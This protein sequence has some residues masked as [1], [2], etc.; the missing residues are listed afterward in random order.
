MKTR[1]TIL[2]IMI[3]MNLAAMSASAT[4]IQDII[5]GGGSIT[6]GHF[7]FSDFSVQATAI[8]GVSPFADLIDIDIVEDPSGAVTLR[9]HGAWS[10]GPLDWSVITGNIG[11]KVSVDE[12]FIAETSDVSVISSSLLGD[13]FY[14]MDVGIFDGDPDDPD[15]DVV[16]ASLLQEGLGDDV[17]GDSQEFDTP[18]QEFYVNTGLYLRTA[19]DGAVVV[20][21]EFAQT[22]GGSVIITPEPAT[23]SLL[24]TG[25]AVVF[26]RRFR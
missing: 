22:F 11:Y 17:T 24:L 20:L 15:S 6:V 2:A 19:E 4:T 21:S 23:I 12:E 25:G 9:F 16:A 13:A 26:L 8:G 7:T 3:L 1:Q 10:A 5:D 14:L 18:L